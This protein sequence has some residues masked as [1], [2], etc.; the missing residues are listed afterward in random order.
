MNT[1]RA[2]LVVLIATLTLTGFA[3]AQPEAARSV[4]EI[5]QLIEAASEGETVTIPAGR[6]EGNLRVSKPVVLDGLN[7]VVIDGL[8]SGTVVELTVPGITIRNLTIRGSGSTVDQEPAGIRAYDGPIII[9][10]NRFEEV[11]FGID[12]RQSPD[13]IIRHNVVHGKDLELGRRGDG[14]RLWWSHGCQIHDNFVDGLRDMVFWYS[15]DLRID[16]NR[17]VNSRY[18]LHFMYSHNTVLS[19]NDLTENSVG[20]Y[21]MYSNSITLRRNRII[22]NRG[23]SGYG[24]GL[25]DCDDITVEH[26]AILA[27]RVGVYVDNSPS[28]FDSVGLIAHNSLSFN[29]I[30]L[31]ATPITHNN[32]ITA[33]AFVENEEQVAVHGGGQL[34]N[35]VFAKDGFGNFW[36]SYA[37]F[38]LAGDGIGDSPYAPR[39]VFRDLLAR[40]PNLRIFVHSP[41]QQAIELTARAFPDLNPEPMFEDPS[42]LTRPPTLDLFE[43]ATTPSRAPMLAVACVLLLASGMGIWIAARQNSIS[44]DIVQRSAQT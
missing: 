30:G 3:L 27:N 29:E 19:E 32:V 40:E 41:A 12:L 22:N 2:I 20:I 15:E 26:N 43:P 23:S 35:N 21:L 38:D 34:N 7:A 33:N 16:R 42:P 24:I 17:V 39:N 6:Y 4:D 8:N 28:S 14:I 9:E 1:N 31:L 37:G 13:S 44:V 11:Y 10:H 18:G 36:S 25:K 5:A